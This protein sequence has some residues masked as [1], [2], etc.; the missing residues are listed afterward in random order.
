MFK[1]KNII[2]CTCK[3][4][5]CKCNI[6]R[7]L[8]DCKIEDS[9]P[10][11]IIKCMERTNFILRRALPFVNRTPTKEWQ[12][13]TRLDDYENSSTL[14]D[15]TPR[16]KEINKMSSK[17]DVPGIISPGKFVKSPPKPL[18]KPAK[19]SSTPVGNW[20]ETKIE[21][22]SNNKVVIY[23][24][25]QHAQIQNKK[26]DIYDSSSD[27][28]R[29]ITLNDKESSG[30]SNLI[31]RSSNRKDSRVIV[32]ENSRT[33]S[34]VCDSTGMLH[35]GPLSSCNEKAGDAGV[36]SSCWSLNRNAN[37]STNFPDESS[38]ISREAI[39]EDD[40]TDI[41]G[42]STYSLSRSERNE[43]DYENDDACSE[44]KESINTNG[45]QEIIVKVSPCREDVLRIEEDETLLEDYWSL[46]GDTT[47]FKADWS[48][49]Q[50]WRLR[51]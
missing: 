33:D 43:N 47:G 23:F 10:R 13:A 28:R 27:N 40:S 16:P 19:N 37:E 36:S 21:R 20:Q 7:E 9:G 38:T 49:V 32:R 35:R 3:D 1:S 46:P 15:V 14:E 18:P 31:E 42:G 4:K 30:Y 29:L 11:E 45:V 12:E 22:D 6:C 8:R 41:Q 17:R 34:T 51:G 25:E 50:Q 2:S 48:F 26:S 24:G 5:C 39:A 44:G